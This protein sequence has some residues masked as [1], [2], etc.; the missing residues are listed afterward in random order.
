MSKPTILVTGATGKTGAELVR[1]LLALGFPVRAVVRRQ[2]ERSQRLRQAGAET[3]I[4]DMYDYEQLF[5][6]LRGVT[7][8]YFLPVMRP[9]M[10][11]SAVAFAAAARDARLEHVLQMSQWTSSP[12]HPSLMTRQ[13]WLV[14]QLFSSI[15]GVA[16]TIINP[17]MFADNFLRTIDMASLQ[18]I[19]PVLSGTSRSA[20]IS[21]E[22][23]ARVAAAILANPAPHVGKSYRP[24]GPRL[25]SAQE[26][27]Q[28]IGKVVGHRVIPLDIPFWMF[29]KVARMQRVH[30]FEVASYRNY[31]EDHKQGAFEVDGGVTDVVAQ[32]T[33]RPAESF[34]ETARRYAAQPRATQTMSNRL[35]AWANFMIT[36]MFPG[37]KLDRYDRSS[38]IPTPTEPAQ[39]MD[40]TRWIREHT[41]RSHVGT[42]AATPLQGALA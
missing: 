1:E 18:G 39:C 28:I 3:V 31:M 19:Y 12:T 15:P 5:A 9:Y 20:P 32:L 33:G 4:A 11:Q 23:I 2:D 8:A 7:R 30:P 17:G 21:N 35:R 40:S 24:T 22:D 16:H 13:T 34:E 38:D 27:A 6:A 36:P 42:G 41:A 25:M 29:S 26:M 10:I 37:S 14:D